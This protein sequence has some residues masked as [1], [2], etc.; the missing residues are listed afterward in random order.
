MIDVVWV[1]MEMAYVNDCTVVNFQ[2]ALTHTRIHVN[3][4]KCLQ[5]VTADAY[6]YSPNFK[7]TVSMI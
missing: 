4:S 7:I 3:F 5:F 1:G 2:L 6:C